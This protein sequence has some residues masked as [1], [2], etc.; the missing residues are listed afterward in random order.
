MLSII[1]LMQLSVVQ[2][3]SDRANPQK[4]ADRHEDLSN[5]PAISSRLPASLLSK[6][7]VISPDHEAKDLHQGNSNKDQMHVADKYNVSTAASS[8]KRRPLIQEM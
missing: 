5:I 6:L 2:S 4:A 3:T 1:V 8:G 7:S